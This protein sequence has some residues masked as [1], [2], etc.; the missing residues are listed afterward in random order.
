[1]TATADGRDDHEVMIPKGRRTLGRQF[2]RPQWI[3]SFGSFLS[4][5]ESMARMYRGDRPQG[6]LEKPEPAGLYM[7]YP[8]WDPEFDLHWI[9]L[10]RCGI[11]VIERP[12]FIV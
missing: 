6:Q 9:P 11:V 4:S 3:K 1:M 2:Y 8:C 7:F 5:H 12:P 10:A